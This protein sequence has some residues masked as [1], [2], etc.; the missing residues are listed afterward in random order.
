MRYRKELESQRPRGGGRGVG[1]GTHGEGLPLNW[2]RE[3]P[4]CTLE[5]RQ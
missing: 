4:N 2:V 3:L 1:Q 5:G